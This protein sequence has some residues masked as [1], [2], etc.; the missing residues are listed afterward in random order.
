MVDMMTDEEKDE[1]DRK[2]KEITLAQYYRNSLWNSGNEIEA[3]KAQM[4]LDQLW[5]EFRPLYNK[6]R[7]ELLLLVDYA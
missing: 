2:L 7:P 1:F 4:R 5:N 6:Y 3:K